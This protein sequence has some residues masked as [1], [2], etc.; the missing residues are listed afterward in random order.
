M[1][2]AAAR[3][4]LFCLFV[5]G[6]GL[7]E[8]LVQDLGAIRPLRGGGHGSDDHIREV[9]RRR[10][11]SI[12]PLLRRCSLRRLL[13]VKWR[14]LAAWI[15]IH[16]VIV[17]RPATLG[18]DRSIGLRAM[19]GS[20]G[21]LARSGAAERGPSRDTRA[22]GPRGLRAGAG[23][24]AS[25]AALA[26]CGD[27]G[28]RGLDVA[29]DHPRRSR[30]MVRT[31]CRWGTGSSTSSRSHKPLGRRARNLSEDLGNVIPASARRE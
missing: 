19:A 25:T 2:M 22:R 24:G 26:A 20:L 12:T 13:R 23:Q 11:P 14:A 16:A 9:D 1:R 27:G 6:M 21:H 15:V 31:T 18:S 7:L 30:G 5:Y 29:V 3:A 4:S 17:V 8:K 28:V 10:D